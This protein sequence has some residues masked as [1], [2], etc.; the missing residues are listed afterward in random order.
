[1]CGA[2]TCNKDS[3]QTV[4]QNKKRR[5]LLPAVASSEAK[6]VATEA[7]RQTD[8]RRARKHGNKTYQA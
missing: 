6:S 8:A 5:R 3:L 2:C 1:M 4:P 7:P